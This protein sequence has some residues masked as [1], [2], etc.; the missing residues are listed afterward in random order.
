MMIRLDE[1]DAA[2]ISSGTDKSSKCHHY[3]PVYSWMDQN[4]DNVLEIG[5]GGGNSILAWIDIFPQAHIFG[6]DQSL[7]GGSDALE[8][9]KLN[10]RVHLIEC[11]IEDYDPQELPKLDL[12]VDDGSHDTRNVL[13]GWRKL[14]PLMAKDSWYVIEDMAGHQLADL[15]NIF[16]ADRY[17][18]TETHANNNI[19]AVRCA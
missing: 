7:A 4:I 14:R 11:N 5:V 2:F 1:I 16:G 3:A 10:P 12:V 13:T 19:I 8:Q 18:I 9:A 17:W 6:L 15:R